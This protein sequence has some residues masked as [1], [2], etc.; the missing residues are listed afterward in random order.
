[1]CYFHC[2]PQRFPIE[3]WIN[4]DVLPA[5]QISVTPAKRAKKRASRSKSTPMAE[6]VWLFGFWQTRNATQ[7]TNPLQQ[8]WPDVCARNLRMHFLPLPL[9]LKDNWV[10]EM[11]RAGSER[12]D[13]RKVHPNSQLN[14][15][16]NS[17]T[18]THRNQVLMFQLADLTH[19]HHHNLR[20]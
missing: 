10:R 2:L 20:S 18:P 14:W 3:L 17:L 16:S 5:G 13:K 19:R 9:L 15:D 8:Q 6:W 1:M 7:L 12:P 11:S 4:K